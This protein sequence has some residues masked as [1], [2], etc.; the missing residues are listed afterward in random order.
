MT[1]T[2]E[3]T[4]PAPN[5]TE[6]PDQINA[7]E[8]PSPAI[9]EPTMSSGRPGLPTARPKTRD[10]I[11]AQIASAKPQSE[12]IDFFGADIEFRQ[13]TIGTILEM[14]QVEASEA[15]FMM[16]L[17]FAFVPDTNEKV[18]ELTDEDWLRELP[19]GE[20]MQRVISAVNKLLGIGG[21]AIDELI[22]DAMKSDGQGSDAVDGDD[23]RSGAE[24]V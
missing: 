2:T 15:S 3:V 19:F 11:R 21:R 5:S 20:D 9:T 23:G 22:A 8:S 16:L 14:R 17:N 10:A 18:F 13:P 4:T 6:V 12:V 1:G 7:A 24:E